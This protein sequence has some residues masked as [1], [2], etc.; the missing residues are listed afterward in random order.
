MTKDD[1]WAIYGSVQPVMVALL[2]YLWWLPPGQ[3]AG[4][5]EHEQRMNEIIA[6]MNGDI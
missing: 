3:D 2:E 6:G 4:K 1:C 5:I